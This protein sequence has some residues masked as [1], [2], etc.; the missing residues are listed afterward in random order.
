MKPDRHARIWIVMTVVA[1][2]LTITTKAACATG[3]LETTDLALERATWQ[4]PILL[5]MTA[6][7]EPAAPL[8]AQ[9]T[10]DEPVDVYGFK[11]KSPRRAFLQSFLIPGWGQW[12]NGSR[13]KPF[14][15]LGLEAAGWYGVSHFH[16]KGVDREDEYVAYA[17][18]HWDSTRYFAGLRRVFYPTEQFP[19]DYDQRLMDTR[20]YTYI[21]DTDSLRSKT[22][23]HHAYF[24]DTLGTVK[25]PKG[26]YYENVG[27]YSQFNFG[28]DDYR[29]TVD[30]VSPTPD[31]LPTGPTDTARFNLISANRRHYLK[32]RDDAN[33]EYKRASTM[34]VA[35][36][37][38]HLLSAFEAA[39]GARRYNRAQDRF[40]TVDHQI[41]LVRGSDGK[42][43]PRVTVAYRF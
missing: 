4:Q 26:E 12:Y 19:P 25:V 22:F 38:N 5:S 29:Y 28:W 37:A 35:T 7:S 20:I 30:S 33:K 40:G 8:L 16:S 42:L 15:F 2:A 13:I 27:K 39:I 21:D 6:T 18:A 32:L 43:M 17:D 3:S 1:A 11:K 31:S 41:R 14:L 10:G 9:A 24:K 23:S 36:I 34:L